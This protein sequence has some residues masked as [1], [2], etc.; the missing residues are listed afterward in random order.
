MDAIAVWFSSLTKSGKATALLVYVMVFMMAS[1]VVAVEYQR[2]K[3][4]RTPVV[5]TVATSPYAQETLAAATEER[6]IVMK[7]GE[8]VPFKTTEIED[9]TMPEGQSFIQ[10]SGVNGKRDVTYEIVYLDGNEAERKEI[11]SKILTEPVDEVKI[12]GTAGATIEPVTHTLGASTDS[13][14]VNEE[15]SNNDSEQGPYKLIA[16]KW[17]YGGKLRRCILASEEQ[18]YKN[19]TV[20]GTYA[21]K[22]ACDKAR[23]SH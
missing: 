8:T 7:L 6:R 11:E 1:T 19:H 22:E 4:A 5:E 15:Q 16:T 17:R 20:L 2:E 23:T 13:N 9:P 10:A 3:L 21:T 12:V 18:N 14:P